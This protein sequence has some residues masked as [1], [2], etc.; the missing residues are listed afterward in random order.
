ML[1][2]EIVLSEN[3]KFSSDLLELDRESITKPMI[4]ATC[5]NRLRTL[6]I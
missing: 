4:S 2:L 3:V 5:G 6:L 1:E